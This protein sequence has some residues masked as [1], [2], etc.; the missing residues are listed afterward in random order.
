MTINSSHYLWGKVGK[1][2]LYPE[3]Y[4]PLLY[5]SIDVGMVAGRICRTCLGTKFVLSFQNSFKLKDYEETINF[6]SFLVSI[7]DIGKACPPFQGQIPE[8]RT[9]LSNNG[10]DFS[11]LKIKGVEHGTV[12]AKLICDILPTQGKWPTIEK[13]M[14]QKLSVALGGHHGVFPRKASFIDLGIMVLGQK[15]IWSDCAKDI[16]VTLS[17]IFKA[18]SLHIDETEIT[19]PQL[20][21]LAGLTTISDW[22][23]SSENYFPYKSS[24]EDEATYGVESEL[25][26]QNAILEL[27]WTKSKA[28]IPKPFV[29]MFPACRPPRPLQEVAIAIS[30]SI[31]SPCLIIIE[32]P[33]GEGKTEAA[34]FLADSLISKLK[35]TGFYIAL[36]TTATSNQIFSRTVAYL[37]NRF[38]ELGETA[39]IHLV[40]GQAFLSEE[41]NQ[42]KPSSLFD[43]DSGSAAVRAEEWFTSRKRSLLAPFGVG[44]VDQVLMAALQTRHGFVRLFGLANKVVIIDEVHA[45]DAYMGTLIQKILKWLKELGSSVIILSA[46]LPRTTKESIIQ[47]WGGGPAEEHPC[48]RIT[49]IENSRT[50]V[51]PVPANKSR[52]IEIVISWTNSINL[53]E[54][55]KQKLSNG[56]C[57]LV[58]CNTVN[59]AQEIYAELTK[60]FGDKVLLFHAR[61]PVN[62]RVEIEKSVIQK[63]GRNGERPKS[64]I[65]V[66]T[67]VVEQSLDLDFDYLVTEMAPIDL[68]LQRVG[69]LHRHKETIR[70][71]NLKTPQISIIEPEMASNGMPSFGVNEYIYPKY[72]L[73][74]TWYIVKKKTLFKVDEEIE[75]LVEEVYNQKTDHSDNE[76]LK[77]L[78]STSLL[79]LNE[80]IQKKESLADSVSIPA[81]GDGFFNTFNRELDEDENPS[82]HKNLQALTRDSEPS[83]GVIFLKNPSI[84][85]I[86]PFCTPEMV[87][88][89][90]EKYDANEQRQLIGSSVQISNKGI[91]HDL[92]KLEA[93]PAFKK[94]PSLRFYKHLV[95]DEANSCI[96]GDY[97]VSID[98]HTGITIKKNQEQINEL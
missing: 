71:E 76:L 94:T 57:A 4:H 2:K 19:E 90:D 84:A 6:L 88:D 65:L 86:S 92:L 20:A 18:E 38:K 44:T 79:D 82:L 35:H 91:F 40:H 50:I 55:F 83:V 53:T 37:Q 16:I 8:A 12:S 7:H 85:K 62:M 39:N 63:F 60:T 74:K 42:L 1:S 29:Q 36:P 17:R 32:A 81:P 69:R 28:I 15:S 51:H 61:F 25:Q 73:L 21:L 13:K 45:Y 89:C 75:R 27:G 9:Y 77:D 78:F 49:H 11:Q 97:K 59:K 46:T 70:P 87:L 5:H 52:A 66:A 67:Q 54:D 98:C 43:E 34:I 95:V 48:P 22:I 80:M 31:A 33:M 3:K 47:A 93:L 68:M 64:C 41:Y 56:G 72:L 30:E 96:I 10:F 24:C 58:V 23:G 14:V 26:A